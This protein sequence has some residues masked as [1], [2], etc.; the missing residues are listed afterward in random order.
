MLTDVNMNW[1]SHPHRSSSNTAT[2]FECMI[3]KY[4]RNNVDDTEKTTNTYSHKSEHMKIQRTSYFTFIYLVLFT[5]NKT[6]MP[7]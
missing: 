3:V 7:S 5:E 1:L 6:H 2:A 4:L